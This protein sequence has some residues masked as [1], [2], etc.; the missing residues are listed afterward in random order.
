[1]EKRTMT[2]STPY[3]LIDEQ[4]LLKNLRIIKRIRDLSGAKSVL[5]LKCFSTWCV[6]DLMK[7]YMDETPSISL[8]EAGLEYKKFEKEVPAYSV[9]FS[10][11][12]IPQPCFIERTGGC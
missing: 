1:M 10:N 3:Y 6:F 5:A 8:Y 12:F 2:L 4:K 11:L 9:V 7:K